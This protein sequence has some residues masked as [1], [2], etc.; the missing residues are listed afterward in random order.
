MINTTLSKE[1]EK[2]Q[3]DPIKGPLNFLSGALTAGCLAWLAINMSRRIVVYFTIHPPHYESPISQNIA[4]TLKTLLVGLSF[5]AVF[6]TS[7]V[8]LGLMLVFF[9]SLFT[10]GY[11]SSA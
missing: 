9:R 3:K 1:T 4:V 2:K 11:K 10:K 7:F 6:S 5:I 8:A